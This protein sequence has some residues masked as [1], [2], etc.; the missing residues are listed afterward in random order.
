MK[1][2]IGIRRTSEVSKSSIVLEGG[3]GLYPSDGTK[4][5]GRPEEE[6][7][8]L[9]K[10]IEAFSERLGNIDWLNYNKVKKITLEDIPNQ[11]T[12]EG[13]SMKKINN[14]DRQNAKIKMFTDNDDFRRPLEGFLGYFTLTGH[15]YSDLAISIIYT[16]RLDSKA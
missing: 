9:N 7:K 4:S 8:D 3:E 13:G 1:N 16:N 2:I 5:G 6:L 12:T 14:A 10:I 15:I 11:I